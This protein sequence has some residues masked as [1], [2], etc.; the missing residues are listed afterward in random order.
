M[1]KCSWG[2]PSGS[3]PLPQVLPPPPT[4][5]H[6]VAWQGWW[7]DC[8]ENAVLYLQTKKLPFCFDSTKT[9]WRASKHWQSSTT[10]L[11]SHL[12][13]L[14]WIHLMK[15]FSLSTEFP[16][17]HC[18][19]IKISQSQSP[20][21]TFLSYITKKAFWF[22]IGTVLDALV[23]WPKIKFCRSS[24][25]LT[26]SDHLVMREIPLW[27]IA[28]TWVRLQHTSREE[29]GGGRPRVCPWGQVPWQG[30]VCLTFLSSRLIV[31]DLG[32]LCFPWFLFWMVDFVVVVPFLH[33]Y[34]ILGVHGQSQTTFCLQV[35]KIQQ[36]PYLCF[37]WQKWCVSLCWMQKLGGALKAHGYGLSRSTDLDGDSHRLF[38][39]LSC[40]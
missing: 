29:T 6:T 9:T 23:Q 30:R 26:K 39:I 2:I 16:T 25:S 34:Y 8:Q 40:H 4:H 11:S 15:W 33:Q 36:L 21:K 10:D 17:N 27:K 19:K 1:C 38:S 20:T 22:S 3:L 13:D 18:S 12:D 35:S 32:L 31:M 5:T 14:R 37:Q 28:P 24:Y 7:F